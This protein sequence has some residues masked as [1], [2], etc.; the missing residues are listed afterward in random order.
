MPNI[1]KLS[2]VIWNF[3]T[4]G[5]VSNQTKT[6][7][8]EKFLIQGLKARNKIVFDFVFHYYYSGL[9][10][11]AEQIVGN[12]NVSEDIVQDLFVKL[13]IKNKQIE[14]TGSLKNYLFTAVKNQSLDYL[15]REKKKRQYVNPELRLKNYDENL[16]TLWL[17]ESELEAVVQKSLNNLPPRCREIFVLS[18]FEGLKNMDIA[19]KFNISKRTVELQISNA[20]KQLRIDL[21]PYLPL[22]L[23]MFL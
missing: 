19:E 4:F 15:K 2:P 18:R 17:A 16:C 14:I 21:K 20:L 3:C 1:S 12:A 9:C 23:L 10:A 13:W 8:D 7:L 11:F 5:L 22:F 6:T